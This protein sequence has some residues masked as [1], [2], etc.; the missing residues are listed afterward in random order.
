MLQ[1]LFCS[2]RT[3][4]QSNEQIG[5]I[6]STI[7]LAIY[8][9]DI[10]HH[11]AIMLSIFAFMS[12]SSSSVSLLSSRAFIALSSNATMPFVLSSHFPN[13]YVFAPMSLLS[14]TWSICLSSTFL[15]MHF[16][17]FLPSSQQIS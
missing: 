13:V 7:C 10:G 15:T 8:Y 9:P 1:N 16:I 14:S 2:I 17:C 11:S 12:S 5:N 4:K 6:N 3:N